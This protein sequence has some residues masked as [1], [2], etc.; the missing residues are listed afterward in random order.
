[1]KLARITLIIAMSLVAMSDT[2]AHGGHGGAS[3][4]SGLLHYMVSHGFLVVLFLAFLALFWRLARRFGW[5]GG[6]AQR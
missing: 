6:S 4:P 2:F 1:M 3:N 5:N